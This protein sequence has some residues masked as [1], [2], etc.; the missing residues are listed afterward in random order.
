MAKFNLNIPENLPDQYFNSYRK[1]GNI[2]L[3][4]KNILSA[5]L[6][7]SFFDNKHGPTSDLDIIA[8]SKKNI[9]Q[10]KQLSIEGVFVELFIYSKKE[11]YRSFQEG[12]YQDMNMMGY[13]FIMF[14]K[15]NILSP[16]RR[17]AK[18][19]FEKGPEKLNK[20]QET[21]L[22]YLI[23]D[24]YCNVVDILE[25]DHLGASALMNRNIWQAVEIYYRLK[26]IWFCR[27]K[28]ML[29]EMKRI[30]KNLHA[31][32]MK[33]YSNSTGDINSMFA[34]YKSVVE[35]II[36]PYKLDE[37]FVWQSKPRRGKLII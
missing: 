9:R 5:V 34:G 26:A 23:W 28:G 12:D 3:S 2:L 25:K 8:I 21:Y 18:R 37:H 32:L 35:N 15:I 17:I 36:A 1:I 13:G 19:F 11:L 14:D 20:E 33:F 16:I 4:D 24:S 10:R 7:G 30:D 29:S 6:S 27:P 31:K 22:K